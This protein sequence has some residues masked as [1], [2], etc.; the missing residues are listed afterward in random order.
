M[1]L[2]DLRADR[3][4]SV[5]IVKVCYLWGMTLDLYRATSLDRA[6]SWNDLETG[7]RR[8]RAVIACRDQDRD[9]LWSLIEAYLVLNGA[10]GTSVSPRTLKAYRWAIDRFLTYAGEQAFNITDCP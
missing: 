6:R 4:P 7:E 10:S 8:R 3:R 1:G 5:P 2:S 9:A